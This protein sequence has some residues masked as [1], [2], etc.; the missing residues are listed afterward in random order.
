MNQSQPAP[1]AVIVLCH[2]EEQNLPH[3]L[4]SVAGWANEIFVVDSGSSDR[5]LDIAR[6]YSAKV[7]EHPFETH[8]KQWNWALENVPT[9]A[10]WILAL[11]A[12]HRVTPELRAEI[13][14]TL[15]NA[16]PS[17]DGYYVVRRQIF[18]GRWIKHGG[19]YPKYL[20]KLF[21]RGKG[22]PDED[23]LAD[24]HFYVAGTTAKLRNDIIEHN[25]KE[26]DIGLWSEKHILYASRQAREEYE[27]RRV[28][29]KGWRVQPAL[30]GTPDQRTI[31]TKRIW[32]RMPLYLRPFLYFFYRYFL[33]LG[34]LD[35]KEGFVFHFLQAFWYRMLVDIKLEELE[36]EA[37][38][39]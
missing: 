37:A 29:K 22:W 21:R 31:W 38:G 23:E 7:M 1:P 24:H 19:Y 35:G 34:F 3:C 11:D 12:D 6:E 30:F 8:A 28:S 2:N 26:D 4:S 36:R 10:E 5:S 13:A 32:Y 20:L 14:E 25:R 18:R 33:R 17:V 16:P 15:P 39:G 27:R 9:K